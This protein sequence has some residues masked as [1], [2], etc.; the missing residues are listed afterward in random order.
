M[1][2]SHVA[3]KRIWDLM[4]PPWSLGIRTLMDESQLLAALTS[5]DGKMQTPDRFVGLSKDPELPLYS[6]RASFV[7]RVTGAGVLYD[8][9]SVLNTLTQAIN[10]EFG[11]VMEPW[12]K[13][14]IDFPTESYDEL[15]RLPKE[16][17]MELGIFYSPGA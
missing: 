6:L 13:D 3:E 5:R 10:Y 14:R 8:L 15:N 16:R 2:D 11:R 4:P 9:I 12:Y 1:L 17:K 7:D